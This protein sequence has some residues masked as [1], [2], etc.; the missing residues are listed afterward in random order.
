M[1]RFFEGGR[2]AIPNSE[3]LDCP[4]IL[5]SGGAAAG[6]ILN[7]ERLGTHSLTHPLTHTHT[8]TSLDRY[9]RSWCGGGLDII[10]CIFRGFVYIYAYLGDL[11]IFMR[12]SA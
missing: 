4:P 9:P 2:G 7:S 10:L 6:A 11:P 8:Y 1:L 12:I 3:G 5:N